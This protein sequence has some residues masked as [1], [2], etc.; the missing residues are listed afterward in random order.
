MTDEE[1][2]D[3]PA[4]K[5]T[6]PVKRQV[7]SSRQIFKRLK[8]LTGWRR[9]AMGMWRRPTESH[10]YGEQKLDFSKALPLIDELRERSDLKVSP[11]HVFVKAVGDMF[12]VYPEY[13][14]MLRRRRFYMRQ[15]ADVFMQVA[16][17]EGGGDLGGIKVEAVDRKTILDLA[18]EVAVRAAKVRAR[19]DKDLEKTKSALQRLPP[20]LMPAV[21]R[22]TDVLS[23]DLGLNLS[24]L[25][26]KPD[27]WGGAMVT[28]IG[29]LGLPHGYP[30]LVPA[31]RTPILFCIGALR[32]EPVAIDGKVEVRP[33]MTVT[34]TFDHRVFDGLQLANMCRHLK[35]R[36]ESPEWLLDEVL[37]AEPEAESTPD[38][39]AGEK[40]SLEEVVAEA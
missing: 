26:V 36:V 29:S 11:L 27:A 24:F 3:V 31:S 15:T 21:V 28:N 20:E 25:G 8:K 6:L 23:N 4:S 22:L 40:P 10:V 7:R 17:R 18:R 33:M 35:D 37:A 34:G 12:H 16:I 2:P 5:E 39:E 19:E 30:P 14:V 32:D 13:N 38:D 9:V 1:R